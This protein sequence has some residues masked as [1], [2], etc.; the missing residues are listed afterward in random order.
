MRKDK[1]K[2]KTDVNGVGSCSDGVGH[3][4]KF[5]IGSEY[6]ADLERRVFEETG[7][8]VEQLV[9]EQKAG[10]CVLLSGGVLHQVLNTGTNVALAW[11]MQTE[12]A[13]AQS[14]LDRFCDCSIGF[15]TA[16]S[17]IKRGMD[18]R[19][20]VTY[21]DVARNGFLRTNLGLT[22]NE[23]FV[24]R[25]IRRF[26]YWQFL[27]ICRIAILAKPAVFDEQASGQAVYL[28]TK[29]AVEIGA[30]N[31][32][33]LGDLE[34]F[35]HSQA[36]GVKKQVSDVRKTILGQFGIVEFEEGVEKRVGRK[37]RDKRGRFVERQ[38]VKKEVMRVMP[39]VTT[40]ANWWSEK[41]PLKD[42]VWRCERILRDSKGIVDLKRIFDEIEVIDDV[43]QKEDV[44]IAK[45]LELLLKFRILSE[46]ESNQVSIYSVR[47]RYLYG[48]AKAMYFPTTFS[49]PERLKKYE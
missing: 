41:T 4:K 23:W 27:C 11:N 32:D 3:H 15:T 43:V 39:E 2:I 29:F 42:Y 26:Q 6:F 30:E 31:W 48:V 25:G 10:Q 8:V 46:D 21:W 33:V 35:W 37:K 14:L 49:F 17:S 47:L 13:L 36:A 9:V 1:E 5:W 22:G 18:I 40:F 20:L 38:V 24:R 12:S 44:F 16:P 45:G 19:N 34:W 7:V 28:G